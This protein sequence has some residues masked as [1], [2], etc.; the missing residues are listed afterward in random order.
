M[1]IPMD[2]F[3]KTRRIIIISII[4]L[5][6][7]SLIAG[8]YFFIFQADQTIQKGSQAQ[9][10]PTVPAQLSIPQ[11]TLAAHAKITQVITAQNLGF[12]IMPD[13]NLIYFDAQK[14]AFAMYN[15]TTQA[16]VMVPGGSFTG[17]NH[18]VWSPSGTWEVLFGNGQVQS[19]DASSQQITSL[20][21]RIDS[22]SFADTLP[23]IFYNFFD[24]NNSSLS[25]SRANGSSWQNL[26]VI[27]GFGPLHVTSS[28]DNQ[29]IAFNIV[30]DQNSPLYL[31]NV[32]S[33]KYRA[34]ITDGNNVALG[35]SPDGKYVLFTHTINGGEPTLS[36]LNIYAGDRIDFKYNI[37]QAS[38]SP[39]SS[40]IMIV[41]M[42][43]TD[44]L[45]H[46]IDLNSMSALD[47][48]LTGISADSRVQYVKSA[49]TSQGKLII[50]FS[51]PSGIYEVTFS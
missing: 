28:P 29:F 42:N 41:S 26:A 16:T 10:I 31:F 11:H 21:P 35:W 9:I 51:T 3:R 43:G 18:I 38:F 6:I 4:N 48:P 14:D 46:L 13:G 30:Q 24:G 19:F 40:T 33:G 25:F 32:A 36:L 8:W 47:I 39:D 7:F 27:S 12:S 17:I 2:G 5:V 34:A 15:T 23:D 37:E 45:M 49:F 44:H 1:I 22:V 50:Y 20:N